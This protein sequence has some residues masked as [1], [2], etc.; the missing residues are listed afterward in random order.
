MIA[1]A[2]TIKKWAPAG[3]D[4]A[5]ELRCILRPSSRAAWRPAVG[6][7]VVVEGTGPTSAGQRAAVTGRLTRR[8]IEVESWRTEP[9]A[10]SPWVLGERHHDVG[11]EHDVAQAVLTGVPDQWRIIECGATKTTS[12][13]RVANLTVCRLTDEMCDWLSRQPQEP[14]GCPGSWRTSALMQ[15]PKSRPVKPTIL[16]L[17]EFARSGFLEDVRSGP[18]VAVIGE[19]PWR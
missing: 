5:T 9:V 14:Y 4:R 10:T 12:G 3:A 1:K 8:A 6:V 15:V 11:V 2:R 18:A 16:T 7:C 19:L 13:G 17:E